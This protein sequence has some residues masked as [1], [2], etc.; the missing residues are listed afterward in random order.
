MALTIITAPATTPVSLAEAKAHLNVDHTD[1]DTLIQLIIEAATA[2]CDGPV[3]FLGRA[4][5]SQQWQLTLD[6]FPENEIKIPLPPLIAVNSIEY[7]DVDGAE[8]TVDPTTYT[9]D[10]TSEP[11]WI[12]CSRRAT[13]TTAT[14]LRCR[15]CRPISRPRSFCL[16]GRSTPTA[17]MKL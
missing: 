6:E 12:W 8:Q 7:D 5:V 3:G 9:V 10:L 2:H 14:R 15:K 13:P 4:L 16:L 17:K 11:G 1:D